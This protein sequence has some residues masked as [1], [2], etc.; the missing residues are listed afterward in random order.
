MVS[1]STLSNS[2]RVLNLGY[3]PV[4]IKAA[5]CSVHSGSK[6]FFASLVLLSVD[7][8]ALLTPLQLLLIH[9]RRSY[10]SPVKI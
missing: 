4:L 6:I 2:V 8:N 1:F 5:I 10:Y 9:E 3:S 7:K